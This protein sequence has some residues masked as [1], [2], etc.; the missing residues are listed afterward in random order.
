MPIVATVG[1]VPGD[2]ASEL[3]TAIRAGAGDDR[4]SWA[5]PPTPMSGGFTTEMWLVHI[6]GGPSDLTGERVV[7]VM[8]DGE[9]AARE[10][11]IQRHLAAAGYLTPT[12]RLAGDAGTGLQCAWMVMDRVDGRPLL[13]DLSGPGVVITAPHAV[14]SIPNVLGRCAAALH[15]V[16]ADAV[17]RELGSLDDVAALIDRMVAR[18]EAVGG[19]LRHPVSCCR[20]APVRSDRR[21]KTSAGDQLDVTTVPG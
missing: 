2:R 17:H 5:A 19:E 10:T 13:D 4:L 6:D 14:R 20:W 9:T 1:D 18:M 3:L 7:R 12:V 21:H 16:P 11:T 8:A 15:R